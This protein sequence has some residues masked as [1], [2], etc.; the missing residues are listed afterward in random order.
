V[1]DR[2][3]IIKHEVIPKTG[4]FEVRFP[5]GR[6][7]AYFYWDDISGRRL[8]LDAMTSEQALAKAKAL[9]RI[10]QDKFA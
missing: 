7:S 4:S 10:E 9:A 1:N 2:V 5:D 8:R 6:P 3:R